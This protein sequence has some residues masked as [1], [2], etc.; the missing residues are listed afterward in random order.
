MSYCA[1]VLTRYA[2]TPSGFLHLGNLVNFTLID[3]LASSHNARIALRIDD[4]D[5]TRTRQEYL[6][7]IFDALGWLDLSW[8][9]GPTG[10]DEMSS[11]SQ[12]TRIGEYRRARDFLQESGHAYACEC[13]RRH[14]I[15]Y[16]GARCPRSCADRRPARLIFSRRSLSP[17]LDCLNKSL[18]AG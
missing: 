18:D 9:L 12:L 13:T 10:P 8:E 15:D 17:L 14:W 2:P 11:W 1:D 6:T 4:A 3:R 7:D 16:H 5:A